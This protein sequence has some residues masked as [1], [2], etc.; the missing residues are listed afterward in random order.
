[1]SHRTSH[2]MQKLVQFRSYFRLDRMESPTLEQNQLA[3]L[4]RG[5]ILGSHELFGHEIGRRAG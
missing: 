4:E 5:Y 2:S 3:W 1:M